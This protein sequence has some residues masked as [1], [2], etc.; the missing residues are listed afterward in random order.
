MKRKRIN[1]GDCEG[2]YVK[3]ESLSDELRFVECMK[4][5][6]SHKTLEEIENALTAEAKE[7][8]RLID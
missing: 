4:L 3:V 5:Y 1:Y 7:R 8:I 6:K 2:D